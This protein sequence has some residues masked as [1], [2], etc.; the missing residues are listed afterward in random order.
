MKDDYLWDGSGEPDP[1]VKQ[2]EEAFSSLRFEMKAPPL[3]NVFNHV[4]RQRSVGRYY[5]TLAV[6]AAIT[7][8]VMAGALLTR[9]NFKALPDASI[10]QSYKSEPESQLIHS[11]Q[12]NQREFVD[13]VAKD[14][15]L[16]IRAD[17]RD[18]Q[19]RGKRSKNKSD[20]F[21]RRERRQDPSTVVLLE[22]F[23]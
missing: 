22:A 16:I 13:P 8:A 12:P 19:L 2:L 1:E 17:K 6:A 23:G 4:R 7:I 9:I 20:N 21:V 11:Q 5:P 14:T 15:D 3:G 18:V 10:T